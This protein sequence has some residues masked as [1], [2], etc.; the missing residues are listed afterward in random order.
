M[1]NFILASLIA[2]SVGL[3]APSMVTNYDD[4]DYCSYAPPTYTL[5]SS[6]L[7]KADLTAETNAESPKRLPVIPPLTT[8]SACDSFME[9]Y[10]RG[11][12]GSKRIGANQLG[13]ASYVALGMLL[14]YYDTYLNDSII[15]GQYDVE[16]VAKNRIFIDQDS[17]GILYDPSPYATTGDTVPKSE[18]AKYYNYMAS[19]AESSL[20][21][22]LITIGN[23]L[24]YYDPNAASPFG[25]NLYRIMDILDNYFSKIGISQDK[26]EIIATSTSSDKVKQFVREYI[27]KGMPVWTFLTPIDDPNARYSA[28]AYEYDSEYTYAHM[29]LTTNDVFSHYKIEDYYY[30]SSAM[31]IDFKMSHSHSR[32]YRVT[33]GNV[34]KN[35]CYCEAGLF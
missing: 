9:A 28:V 35:Y 33:M 25:A 7:K 20:H 22:K 31:V 16:A 30:F 17:P 6:D 21:A 10:F 23:E 11:L 32:N 18:V 14:S 24:G 2:V 15:P 27:D 19:I 29:G 3:S 1:F 5:S 4:F 26:Y 12:G 13:S 8:Y 34:T